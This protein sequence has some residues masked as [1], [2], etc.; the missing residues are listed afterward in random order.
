[1]D[2]IFAKTTTLFRISLLA[3]AVV[4]YTACTNAL[5]TTG[6]NALSQDEGPV[7]QVFAKVVIT[8]EGG[9]DI[10][11]KDDYVNGTVTVD[12]N[13]LASSWAFSATA[14]IKG[15]GNST[16]G[17]PK[18]PYRIKLDAA[19]S[20][21]GLPADKDWVLLANYSDKTLMRN[22]I[23]MEIGRRLGLPYT[24]RMH[25]VELVL[26]G[27]D[28]GTYVFTE[29][30]KLSPSRTVAPATD[31]TGG[32]LLELD[33]RRDEPARF[34]TTRGQPYSIKDPGSPTAEQSNY[35][36]GYLQEA[37]DVLN[38][39]GFADPVNGYAKYIDVDSFQQW[40]LVSE[41][42]KNVDSVNFSSIYFHKGSGQKL[43][44]GPLWDFDLSAGN[45]DYSDAQTP[46][47]WYVRNSPWFAPLF[48][49][50][51]FAA[52]VKER[53]N[54]L[55]TQRADLDGVMKLIDR[56]AL[57][58]DK[59][60][61]KNFQIWDILGMYVWPNRVVTGS[62]PGEVE[63]MKQWLTTRINWMDKQFN[64]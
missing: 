50:P 31:V 5:S 59:T 33:Q 63:A 34:E 1:M 6:P 12:P 20:M 62:Y 4:G 2:K 28:L 7:S 45:V 35:I 44:M 46:E 60:Q 42:F 14:K 52:Q 61:M 10:V 24:P 41:I 58:L 25:A 18:K 17:M 9:V 37:E 13:G 39:A 27:K 47:G 40:F 48:R 36:R 38:G 29:H 23:A 21:L 53:W 26:N 51:V 55:K 30:V 15:R 32:Y 49:D 64:P 43:R 16:W 57:A 8:T 3:F 11:S 19:A 22:M 54:A 56:T